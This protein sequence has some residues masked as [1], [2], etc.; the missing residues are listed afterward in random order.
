[1]KETPSTKMPLGLGCA[2]CLCSC[3]C[4]FI[5]LFGGIWV[6]YFLIKNSITAHYLSVP[7]EIVHIYSNHSD[8]SCRDNAPGMILQ[9]YHATIPNCISDEYVISFQQN[10]HQIQAAY[11]DSAND[12]RED[13]DSPLHHVHERVIVYY[14]TNVTY[15]TNYTPSSA[16]DTD[17]VYGYDPKNIVSIIAEGVGSLVFLGVGLLSLILPLPWYTDFFKRRRS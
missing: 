3:V 1:M 9:S 7:G 5:F 17:I 6:G 14:N 10:G 12:Q 13:G 16:S 2:T 15:G 4:A 8:G 11:V